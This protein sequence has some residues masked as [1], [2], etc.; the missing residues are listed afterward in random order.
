[1]TRQRQL[2]YDI[3]M[4]APEHYTA[5]EI[6]SLAREKMPSVARGTV[7]RNLGILAQE[8]R[9]RRLEMPCA[10][11][12]YD[13]Q[14][15]PHPHL[16]CEVCGRVEDLAMPEGLLSPLA[17][18]VELTGYDLKLFH[19]CAQCRAQERSTVHES[20]VGEPENTPGCPQV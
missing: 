6:F 13:R 17:Q 5:E 14:F 11:A 20:D 8:G 15:S 9:I 19:I 16:I 12:R 7:Y 2:V 10:P 4:R 1:M 3:V 18:G